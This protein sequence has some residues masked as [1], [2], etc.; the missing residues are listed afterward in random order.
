M[1]HQVQFPPYLPRGR[2]DGEAHPVDAAK[3]PGSGRQFHGIEHHV[4]AVVQR[5]LRQNDIG[6]A[7]LFCRTAAPRERVEQ[8]E[9]SY[10]FS[11]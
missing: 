11:L 2:I 3:R 7:M 5:I 9:A 10:P 4:F 1:T 6:I 8:R